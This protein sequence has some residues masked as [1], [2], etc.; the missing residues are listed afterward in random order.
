MTVELPAIC[1]AD[2]SYNT[3]AKTYQYTIG[4]QTTHSLDI[5]D[6]TF[7][8]TPHCTPSLT[9]TLVMTNGDSMPSFITFDPT[10]PSIFL[11]STSHS[12]ENTYQLTLTATEASG[13]IKT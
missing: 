11:D 8:Y 12:D 1:V 7:T 10:V 3:L 13:Y 5:P 2:I 4:E 6:A 9:Y